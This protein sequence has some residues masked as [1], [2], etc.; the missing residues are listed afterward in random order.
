MGEGC[1]WFRS[2]GRWRVVIGWVENV[3][4]VVIFWDKS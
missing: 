4:E 2:R 1:D 3:G